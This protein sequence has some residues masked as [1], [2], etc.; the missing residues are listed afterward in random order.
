MNYLSL[1]YYP[2]SMKMSKLNTKGYDP[3]NEG[4]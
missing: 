4:E 3:L 1:Y 2:N